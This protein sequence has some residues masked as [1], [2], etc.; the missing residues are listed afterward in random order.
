MS[1]QANDDVESYQKAVP[2]EKNPQC[3]DISD[4]KLLRN[5]NFF[6]FFYF[7]EKYFSYGEDSREEVRQPNA[8]ARS[9]ASY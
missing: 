2:N 8:R 3:K 1:S 9:R 6:D 7:F 5:L 4:G